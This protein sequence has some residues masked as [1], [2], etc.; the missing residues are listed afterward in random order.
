MPIPTAVVRE[1]RLRALITAIAMPAQRRRAALDEGPE[2]APMLAREPRP[3]RLEKAIAVL[4]HDVGHLEGWPGHRFRFRRGSR[5]GVGRRDRHRIE[6]ID[7]GLQVPLREVEIQDR[8]FELHVAEQ[9]LNGA[10]VGAGFQQMRRVRMAQQMRRDALL[11][12]GALRRRRRT[13]P[14]DLRR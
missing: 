3:V 5:R 11:Q 8:V 6:R 1:A 14:R 4:A 13:P 9:Q 2:H 12:P 7:D 10:Q